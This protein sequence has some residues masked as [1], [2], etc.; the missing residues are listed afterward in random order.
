MIYLRYSGY[1]GGITIYKQKRVVVLKQ[2][3]EMCKGEESD[4]YLLRQPRFVIIVAVISIVLFLTFFIF[5]SCSLYLWAGI[6]FLLFCVLG[7]FL[8]IYAIRWKIIVKGTDL[9]IYR[10]K[11]GP[12]ELRIQDI[13]RVVQE[14]YGFAAYK[15]GKRVFTVEAWVAG[16]DLLYDKLHK[17]G[18]MES[19][20][21]RSSFSVRRS[22]GEPVAGALA[23]AFFTLCFIGAIL[24][25][26]DSATPFVYASF[27]GFDLLGVYL[28][29]SSLKWKLKVTGN[30]VVYRTLFRREKMISIKNI[31]K[32]EVKKNSLSLISGGKTI[33]KVEPVYKEYATL[34]EWLQAENIPFYCKGNRIKL[35]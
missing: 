31:E 9:E 8:A 7:I 29:I 23:V 17:L 15:D 14:H 28:L 3:E 11:N 27:I 30:Q 18:K 21:N 19:T 20:L 5:A 32:I 16:S 12:I 33:I 4:Y 6:I 26:N 13:D 10:L 34:I 2:P 1:Y 24:Y 25:P 35:D 22:K